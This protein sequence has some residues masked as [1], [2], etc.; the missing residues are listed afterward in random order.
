[1]RIA[2]CISRQIG[3]DDEGGAL[4]EPADEVEQDLAAGLVLDQSRLLL[5]DLGREQIADNALRLVPALDG[6]RHDLVEGGLH[7]VKLE[8]THGAGSFHQII[9]RGFS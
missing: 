1:V 6:S 5:A 2:I 4:V 7:S 8:L 9:C 3:G